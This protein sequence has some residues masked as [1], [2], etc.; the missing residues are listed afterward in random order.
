MTVSHLSFTGHSPRSDIAHDVQGLKWM[1]AKAT[2]VTSRWQKNAKNMSRAFFPSRSS[3]CFSMFQL[4]FTFFYLPVDRSGH[5]LLADFLADFL[6]VLRVSNRC[7][8]VTSLYWISKP[9]IWSLQ[10]PF[11]LVWYG[12]AT[13]F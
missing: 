5:V 1:G 4:C 2:T 7:Y 9:H 12:Q 6:V 8:H 3:Q 13:F 10:L 11:W